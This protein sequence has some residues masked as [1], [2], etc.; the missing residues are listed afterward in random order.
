MSNDYFRF[1]QFTVWQKLAAMKVCT[2]ACLF[3]AWIADKLSKKETQAEYILDI[4]AGTGLL[5]LMLAQKTAAIIDAIELD[6]S[7]AHQ[8]KENFEASPFKDRLSIIQGDIRQT[9]PIK[10][11]DLII[12]NPPFY[13]K[14]LKSP[15][16][17]R[18]LA[19]HSHSLTFQELLKVVAELLNAQGVFVVLLP[20]QRSVEFIQV[21]ATYHLHLHEQCLVKQTERHSYFR[22]MCLF[23]KNE[24]E[25]ETSVLK[26]KEHGQ[27]SQQFVE[28]LKDYYL[29]LTG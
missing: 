26:I 18:N 8:A 13:E 4:G 5:S 29:N 3:G 27:Y 14:D 21:A 16:L 25:I 19:L 17:Q 12:C 6:A 9:N 7:A 23:R 2:D 15:M 20:H 24:A 11:Y 1:K 10:K 28:L 22:S